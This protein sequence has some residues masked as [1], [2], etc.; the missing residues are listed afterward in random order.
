MLLQ[1]AVNLCPAEF[2]DIFEAVLKT[3]LFRLLHIRDVVLLFTRSFARAL[4]Q[5][6]VGPMRYISYTYIYIYICLNKSPLR[7]ITSDS[8]L[9]KTIV[10]K[11]GRRTTFYDVKQT[12]STG[13]AS[14]LVES[15]SRLA[16]KQISNPSIVVVPS[17]ERSPSLVACGFHLSSLFVH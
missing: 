3:Q 16:L 1:I 9:P 13:L 11:Y 10:V 5:E 8:S 2:A 17:L 7:E 12:K 14:S 4:A 15:R 6:A